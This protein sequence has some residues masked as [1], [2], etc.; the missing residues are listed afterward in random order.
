MIRVSIMRTSRFS[1][2]VRHG[3]VILFLIPFGS[4][5]HARTFIHGQNCHIVPMVQN[6]IN[7]NNNLVIKRFNLP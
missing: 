3:Y 4:I 2:Q 1:I 7:S 5:Y 6:G